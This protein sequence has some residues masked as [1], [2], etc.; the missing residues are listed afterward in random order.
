VKNKSQA[1]LLAI[2]GK[3]SQSLIFVFDEGRW[4]SL[5]CFHEMTNLTKCT[6]RLCFST[7]YFNFSRAAEENFTQHG[8]GLSDNFSFDFKFSLPVDF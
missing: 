2:G 8:N 3:G 1:S 5:C 6:S 7:G 4:P